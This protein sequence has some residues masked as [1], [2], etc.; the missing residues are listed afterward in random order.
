M[1]IFFK[2]IFIFLYKI[3]HLFKIVINLFLSKK[4]DSINIFYGGA[5]SGNIGG[6]L[7]KADRLKTYFPEELNFNMVYILS[8]AN[9]LNKLSIKILKSKN[10]PIIL[11]QNGVFYPSWYP[12]KWQEKNQIMAE[13]Y[14]KADYVFWQSNFCKKSADHFL[15][16]RNLPGEILYNSVDTKYKFFPRKPDHRQFTFLITGKFTRDVFYRIE[17]SLD[18]FVTA[19]EMGADFK[20]IIAGWLEKSIVLY[21]NKFIKKFK[22][23]DS[24]KIIGPYSQSEACQIYQS[25]DVYI[26]TKYLDPCPNSVIEAMACGLPVIYSNSGGIPELVG[27]KCGLGLDVPLDWEEIHV[28]EPLAIAESMHK[29]YYSF[30]EMSF[31]SRKRALEKFDLEK[32][33]RRHETIFKKFLK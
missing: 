31:E 13:I 23:H 1:K 30:E 29:I 22:L 24:L 21:I 28:P 5:R 19:R 6:P 18:G 3:L 10:F 25:A 14:H 17:N 11:N 16:T 20:L 9:Y 7:V 26:T 33:I 15:G 2:N 32:W 8:N 4:K 27:D 12:K